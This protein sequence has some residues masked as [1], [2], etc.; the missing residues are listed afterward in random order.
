M[1]RSHTR[2][3]QRLAL[4]LVASFAFTTQVGQGLALAAAT[5]PNTV[6][7]N[8]ATA[9]Y[10]DGNG[11][12]YTT[13]S[14][15]VTTTVQNAPS[16]SI[17]PPAAQNVAAGQVVVDTY[18]LTNTG[19]AA[20][21]FT[22]PT[23]TPATVGSNGT[24]AGYVIAGTTCTAAAQCN[25]TS[26]NAALA[27]LTPTAPGASIT[28]GVEY[29]VSTTPTPAT[30][31]TVP[32]TLTAA[33]TQPAVVGTGTT[34]N[35]NVPAATSANATATVT[36]IISPQAR[37]DL[38]KSTI[39]PTTSTGD[40][41]FSIAANNGGAFPAVDLQSVKQLLGST[42]AGVLVSD[43]IPTFGGLPLTIDTATGFAP[44][45]TLNGANTGAIATIYYSTSATGASGWSTTYVAGDTFIAAFIS[46]GALGVELPS[47]PGGSSGAGAVTIPQ[48]TLSFNTNQPVGTGAANAGSLSNIANSLIGGNP[49]ATGIVPIIGPFAGSG[50]ADSTTPTTPVTFA[51]TNTT[52]ST[53]TT[54]PGGASNT[55]TSQA[56]ATN[57]V[58]VGP[59]NFPS[60]T[61]SYPA[62]PNNGTGSASNNLDYTA[63][64]FVCANGASINNGTFTC[65][66]PTTGITVPGTYQNSGNGPD[67]LT[68]SVFAPTGFTAQA[69]QATS[70]SSA[71]TSL[72]NTGCQLGAA[73]TGVVASGTSG[74]GPL[75]SVPSQGLGNY[76]VV[77]KPSTSTSAVA[78]F[79]A[80][81][82]VITVLG[83]QGATVSTD[84]NTTHI[85]LYP[86]GP[87]ALTKSQAIVTNCPTGSTGQTAGAVCPGGTITYTVLYLNGAPATVVAG[88]SNVGTEP[89]FAYNAI[90]TPASGAGVFVV[91][92]DG[93]AGTNNW[94][95]YTNG[96][97]AAPTTTG[98]TTFTFAYAPTA[99]TAS[100][101]SKFTATANGAITAGSTG[102]IVFS[103]IVK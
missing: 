61:G 82:S 91:S 42:V 101:S 25:I 55:V 90:T 27:G 78:P 67:T 21:N 69:F 5:T 65:A 24:F 30:G 40:I 58:V 16:L 6:I 3:L 103:A 93:A 39:A 87:I 97:T 96:L 48:V 1:K 35:P 53:G 15:T 9:T 10:N 23:G 99:G 57:T 68:L 60:A 29:T 75:G 73:I 71:I 88:G 19:N 59:L 11:N 86:G 32:T 22:I 41:N 17:A 2:T 28:I 38:Q 76:V 64:G 80:I 62:A 44:T 56:F 92:E 81:D 18:T 36:D 77:Y 84:A 95:T 100:G 43:K 85:V 13:N 12:S 20:G 26:A 14:N 102:T 89:A 7:S 31:G 83:S 37:L 47:K 33:I 34:T 49:G 52:S 98:T 50:E 74:N 66:I 46:G 54:P 70:C 94:A 72:N 79:T 51:L 45:V 8:T 4:S 63:A